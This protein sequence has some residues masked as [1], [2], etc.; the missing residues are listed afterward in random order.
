M[1][2]LENLD[3]LK[4]Q[5]E[6]NCENS[7]EGPMADLDLNGHQIETV[8][9]KKRSRRE[10]EF[11]VRDFVTALALCHNVTPTY[12]DDNDRSVVEFQASSPDEVALVKFADSM[13]MKL[14]ERD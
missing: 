10:Q 11:I 2:D 7:G 5:L 9:V 6:Y 14:I 8:G 4:S 12:P 1:F 3:E 13:G